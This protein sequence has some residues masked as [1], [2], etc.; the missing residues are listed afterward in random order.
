MIVGE[1]QYREQLPWWLVLVHVTLATLVWAGVVARCGAPSRPAAGEPRIDFSHRKASAHRRATGAPQ[2]GAGRRL[3][4]LERRR[5]GRHRWPPATWRAPGRRPASPTSIPRSSSTSRS[6]RPHIALEEG[7]TRRIDWPENAFFHA[8]CP[9]TDRDAVLL[10]GVEP[11]LRWRTFTAEIVDWRRSSASSSSITLGALLADVPHT[12]PSPVTGSATDPELVEELGLAVSRYE[13]PTGIVGVLH[14]TC[15]EAGI[16][17]RA[18]GPPCRTTPRSRRARSAALA[19]C[20]RL[21][22]AARRRDRPRGARA[23]RGRLRAPGER[24]G[25]AGRG[26]RGVRP[27]ARAPPDTLGDETDMPSGDTLAAELTRFLREHEARTEGRAGGRDLGQGLGG[28]RRPA[29]PSARRRVRL[30]ARACA[31]AGAAGRSASPG[32][33]SRRRRRPVVA[34]V[35][36][37]FAASAWRFLRRRRRRDLPLGAFG[38]GRLSASAFATSP[39]VPSRSRAPSISRWAVGV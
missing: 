16:P 1:T 2:S 34:A 21:G 31:C 22:R 23:R 13:G 4:R 32:A 33:A 8:G 18:S 20:T 24:G 30:L 29:R 6:T 27:R 9:G 11:N 12:R 10:L 26:D 35:L 37:A 15:R 5:A 38:C 19:L 14:D 7:L 36:A 28:R 3:P 17:R 25:R 39:I